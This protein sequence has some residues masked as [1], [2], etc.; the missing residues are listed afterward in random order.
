MTDAARPVA[1]PAR[2]IT[3]FTWGRMVGW[4]SVLILAAAGMNDTITLLALLLIV[5]GLVLL[6][7][8]N[9]VLYGLP[10]E[11]AILVGHLAGRWT[12]RRLTGLVAGLV[13]APLLLSPM[14]AIP[15]AMR[16]GSER[17]VAAL[18]AGDFDHEHGP[19]PSAIALAGRELGG[20]CADA[21]KS[22]LAQRRYA[23]VYV[24]EDV[25]GAFDGSLGGRITAYALAPDPLCRTRPANR[26]EGGC[27][28]S[29]RAA[30]PA[31]DMVISGAY[32]FV[33]DASSKTRM[34]LADPGLRLASRLQVW[35]CRDGACV[36]TRRATSVRFNP[37]APLL[38]VYTDAEDY[39]MELHRDWLRVRHEVNTIDLSEAVLKLT[40]GAQAPEDAPDRTAASAEQAA[41]S[42]MAEALRG[43]NDLDARGLAALDAALANAAGDH[44][45]AAQ[46]RLVAAFLRLPATQ[47]APR[48][49]IE[50]LGRLRAQDIA[51]YAP[52][53]AADFAE[54][55]A[56]HD[57]LRLHFTAA[58]L[59]R[60]PAR[61]LHAN[62]GRIAT[63][64]SASPD[65]RHEAG[66]LW[67]RLADLGPAALPAL[68]AG[69]QDHPNRPDV[70]LGA[71]RLGGSAQPLVPLL[72]AQLDHRNDPFVDLNPQQAAS[73]ALLR[74]GRR[75]LVEAYLARAYRE[76]PA[77]YF[78]QL[79][80]VGPA[81][82]PDVCG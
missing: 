29:E 74:L 41:L 8:P 44:D 18:R 75:D 39:G 77:W 5:P 11:L 63:I 25:P 15:W 56:A 49:L 43:G 72:A 27:L 57:S 66:A 1:A 67:Q 65:A 30:Q 13:A 23:R 59:A 4:I 69:L 70:A 3:A 10:V 53:L 32:A 50:A 64:L 2:G 52:E 9:L 6:L 42:A 61:G 78:R 68:R 55:D 46:A 17:T 24:L 31:V 14:A 21:C 79:A 19:A 38:V 48:T 71:C 81:S 28:V 60:L 73:L 22:L 40:E 35:R 7:A 76:I 20:G 26:L 80:S 51:R 37:L 16:L 47:G 33:A 54:A 82:P 45:G 62:G 36:E 12:G 34:N 58:A